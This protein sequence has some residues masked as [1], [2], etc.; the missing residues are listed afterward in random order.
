MIYKQEVKGD[1]GIILK[2]C[3][4]YSNGLLSLCTTK[5]FDAIFMFKFAFLN[6]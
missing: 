1:I 2:L 6:A 5:N 3:V 4:N